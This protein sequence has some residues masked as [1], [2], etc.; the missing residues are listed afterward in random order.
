MVKLADLL[1]FERKICAER[2]NAHF[3]KGSINSDTFDSN[4]TI[5]PYLNNFAVVVQ[6]FNNLTCHVLKLDVHAVTHGEQLIVR[7]KR[8]VAEKVLQV[9]CSHFIKF[10]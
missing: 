10:S 2:V 3:D 9:D 6:E 4:R 1:N 7:W 8:N 5:D